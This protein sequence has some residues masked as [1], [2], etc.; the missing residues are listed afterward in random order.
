MILDVRVIPKASRRLV[1][2]KDNS[3]KVYLTKPAAEGL[4]NKELICL[5]SEYFNIKKYQIRILKGEKSRDK[6]IQ[7]DAR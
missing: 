1:V 5:L 3:L 7:I 4:A 6:L 2:K